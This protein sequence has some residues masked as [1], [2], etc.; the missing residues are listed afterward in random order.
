M[1]KIILPL[2][3]AGAFLAGAAPAVAQYYPQPRYGFHA[4][5]REVRSLQM[6]IDNIRRQIDRLDRRDA[7]RGRTADRL[8]DEANKIDRRLRDKSRD[9][10]DPR[11]AGDIQY[12]LQR[13]EQRVQWAAAD[14]AERFEG[15]REY[16]RF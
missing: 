11:E 14:S 7:I 12:R 16:R 13:L 10:L 2:I 4:D 5:W 6:R 3:A 15:D 9:G 8:M 1:R